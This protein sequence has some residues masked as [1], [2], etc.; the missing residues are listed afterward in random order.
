MI[1]VALTAILG[2]LMS[3][4]GTPVAR[5]VALAYGITDRP[6][7]RLKRQREPVPYLGGLAVAGLV[8]VPLAITFPFSREV[9]GIL[10]AGMIMVLAGLIDDLGGLSPGA[11][12]AAQSIA[13]ITLIK[14]GSR[15]GLPSCRIRWTS[16]SRSS[17]S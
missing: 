10:L 11:K 3:L 13:A 4:W 7:G 12:L 14:R 6:D 8:L 1:V 2:A 9:V 17:G 5:R 16:P 15:S